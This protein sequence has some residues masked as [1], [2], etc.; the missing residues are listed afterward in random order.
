MK[1]ISIFLC[2]L[3]GFIISACS[4]SANISSDDHRIVLSAYMPDNNSD[5]V[6]TR[7]SLTAKQGTMSL[8][9][10]WKNGDAVQLF[11]QQTGKIHALGETRISSLSQDGKSC[12]LEV[13][14]PKDIKVNEGYTLYGFCGRKAKLVNGKIV[15][16]GGLVRKDL[17]S[18]Q[19]PVWFMASGGP[20]SLNV[21][22]KHFGA[23]ELTH[24]INKSQK[25]IAVA[26]RGY[27]MAQTLTPSTERVKLGDVVEADVS[28]P[29]TTPSASV[30]IPKNGTEPIVSWYIPS[31]NKFNNTTLLASVDGKDVE[32]SNTKSSDIA[33]E[34]GKAYHLYTIWNGKKLTFGKEEIT[35][36]KLSLPFSKLS[37]NVGAT[38]LVKIVGGT[39]DY[40][41]V[42]Q[43]PAI[44]CGE[45]VNGKLKVSA[46]TKGQTVIKVR[47]NA[48][49]QEVALEVNVE[50]PDDLEVSEKN[51]TV[52]YGDRKTIIITSGSG[53]YNAYTVDQKIAK[54]T[55]DKNSVTI[56]PVAVGKTY[57]IIQDK[58]TGKEIEIELRVLLQVDI[59]YVPIPAGKGVFNSW[60]E[61]NTYEKEIPSF[62]MSKYEVTF[63]QYDAFCDATGRQKPSDNGW[64]RGKRPVMNLSYYDVEAFANYVGA[65]LPTMEEWMYACSAGTDT[66]Y[67]TGD[68]LSTDLVNYDGTRPLEGCS[69]GVNRGQTK[70]VGSFKPNAW[71]LY[72]MHG[73]VWEWTSTSNGYN[74]GGNLTYYVKGGAYNTSADECRVRYGV[75]FSVATGYAGDVEYYSNVGIRLVLKE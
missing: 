60:D 73:N 26:H 15:V 20:A 32:S 25:G 74:M 9:A 45:I 55:L 61:K 10:K 43:N 31:A 2:V 47:D 52:R 12:V 41:V 67:H 57:L 53:E 22:F 24:F 6:K 33:I 40:S 11:V 29:Q 30:S 70:V 68:C 3:L 14:L 19:V 37:I 49:K 18:L 23:Y 34:P 1:K 35:E 13:T 64:G 50:T 36:E 51:V 59:E 63:E 16:D 72:D 58:K 75:S 8:V 7:V 21:T 62:K 42:N 4:D 56:I 5:T 54:V 17:N 71:G 27:R 44:A 39:G 66:K 69:K 28:K 38:E 46:L 65:R 48:T